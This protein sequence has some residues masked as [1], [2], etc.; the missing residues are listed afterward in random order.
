VVADERVYWFAPWWGRKSRTLIPL[1]R[2]TKVGKCAG[3]GTPTLWRTM[4]DPWR[5]VHPDCAGLTPL[6]LAERQ[7]RL[8]QEIDAMVLLTKE[9]GAV[10]VNPATEVARPL[11]ADLRSGPCGWC[12]HPGI[13]ITDDSY[14]HCHTHMWPP[15]RW[16]PREETA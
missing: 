16:H 12:G 3:C 14:F 9:L 5:I 10:V 2:S 7:R 15:F 6:D 4:G 1:R 11:S 13:A 8:E